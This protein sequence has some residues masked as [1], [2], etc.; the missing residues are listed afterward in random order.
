M[1]RGRAVRVA[2]VSCLAIIF[3]LAA[4]VVRAGSKDTPEDVAKAGAAGLERLEPLTTALEEA[5]AVMTK[6]QK[7]AKWQA[8]C[9]ELAAVGLLRDA[10]TLRFGLPF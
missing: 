5:T 10:L 8:A 1:S 3:L 4:G 7:D 9:V 2:T 6:M